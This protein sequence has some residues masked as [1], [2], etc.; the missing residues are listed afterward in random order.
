[1][2]MNRSIAMTT[3]LRS[4]LLAMLAII[5]APGVQ[6]A[7]AGNTLQSVEVLPMGTQGVQL[8]LTTSGAASE[9][10][11]F[12]IENPARIS[13]TLQDTALGLPQRRIDVRSNGLDRVAAAEADGRTRVVLNLDQM[14]PYASRGEGNRIILTL[15]TAAAGAA[16]AA[17]AMAAA[18]PAQGQQATAAPRMGRGIQTIDFRRAGDASGAGRLI[19]RLGDPRTPVNVRQQG[20]QIVVDFVGADLPEQLRRRFDVTDFATPVSTFDAQSTP[21]GAQL[22]INASGDFEQLAY[23]AEDQYVIEVQSRRQQRAAVAERPT[24]TGERMSATFQDI[25]TRTLLQLIAET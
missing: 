22:V 19:V 7:A 24:Y 9:P 6:A 13:L 10:N 1:I 5:A 21:N 8:V 14:V 18:A 20:S 25:D 15:G 12:A 4:M 2:R 11:A 17:P 3:T 16:A 23:Q